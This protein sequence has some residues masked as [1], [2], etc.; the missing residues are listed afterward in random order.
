MSRETCLHV[1]GEIPG[2][3]L[4]PVLKKKKNGVITN[5]K[6]V[7]KPGERCQSTRVYS[8]PDHPAI[9]YCYAHARLRGLINPDFNKRIDKVR[10]ETQKAKYDAQYKRK[11][12]VAEAKKEMMVSDK[13]TAFAA[14]RKL[15]QI[16]IGQS[17]FDLRERIAEIKEIGDDQKRKKLVEDLVL[18]WWVADFATRLPETIE[19]VADLLGVPRAQVRKYTMTNEFLNAV[20]DHCRHMNKLLTP[21][22]EFINA[23][24]AIGGDKAAI[25]EFLDRS[26]LDKR[27]KDATLL[28]SVSDDQMLRAIEL[29]KIDKGEVRLTGLAKD[30][31]GDHGGHFEEQIDRKSLFTGT[32]Q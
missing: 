23:L 24:K 18:L 25:K 22:I 30:L 19:E 17:G 10:A 13:F 7:R 1:Y 31:V 26:K 4:T 15:Y 32:K 2:E 5:E 11:V 29:S 12:K 28:D 20:E 6:K 21:Q 3:N 27:G 8:A 9:G 16:I 14:E